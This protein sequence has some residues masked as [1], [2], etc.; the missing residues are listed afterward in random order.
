MAERFA[1]RVIEALSGGP[2]GSRAVWRALGDAGLLADLTEPGAGLDRLDA[3][4]AALDERQPLGTVLSVCVQVASALPILREAGGDPAGKAAD[5]AGRGEAVLAFAVTDAATAGSDLM[6]LGTRAQLTDD[7][8]RLDGGKSWIT[9]A[10]GADHALV[11]AR[12]REVRHFTSFLWVLVPMDTPGVVVEPAGSDLFAGAG[13]GHLRFDD[14]TVGRDHLLGAP[15]R[16][17]PT[18]ARHIGTERIAGA[19]WARA[20]CRRAL[21]DTHGRLVARTSGGRPLWENDAVRARFARCLVELRRVDA[22]CAQHTACVPGSAAQ[23]SSMLLKAA[24]AQSLTLVL[25]ECVQLVGADAFVPG[26]LA[27]LRAG[28]AMFGIAGGATGALLAGIA[29]HAAELLGTAP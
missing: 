28:A 24:T 22:M 16:G 21:A 23:A 7:R 15:G 19:L 12:H 25:D 6:A 1:A 26:G 27:E 3:L 4:L 13:L 11:L 20:M 18:F 9:N 29:E 10:C 8:V 5:A 17:L 14:V 2:V